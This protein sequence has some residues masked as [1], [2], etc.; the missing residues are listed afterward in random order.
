MRNG[1]DSSKKSGLDPHPAATGLDRRDFLKSSLAVG[2]TALVGAGMAGCAAVA[3][4]EEPTGE[5]EIVTSSTEGLY[6]ELPKD[7]FYVGPNATPVPPLPVPATWDDVADV[8]VVGTGA[9]GCAATLYCATKGQKVITVEKNPMCGGA[10]ATA[11]AF[12]CQGGT[13]AQNAAGLPFDI[14]ALTT[15][16]MGR[17]AYKPGLS[18]RKMTRQMIVKGPEA[19]DWFIDQGG[20]MKLTT[21]ITY[22]ATNEWDGERG[23]NATNYASEKAVE[24]G[25]D[26]RLETECIRLIKEGERVV[27]IKV[28]ELTSGLEY[29]IKGERGVILCAGGFTG[30]FDMLRRWCPSAAQTCKTASTFP[31]DDGLCVRLGQGAGAAM[32]GWDSF[33]AFDGGLDVGDWYH[34]I[35]EG[36]VQ[37]ARQPWLGIDNRG[38]RYPYIAFALEGWGSLFHQAQIFQGLPNSTGYV[39]FDKNWEKNTLLFNEGGC[40]RGE[41]PQVISPHERTAVDP[42]D[43]TQGVRRG[44]ERGHIK[45][46]DNFADI[47]TQLDLDPAI[48]TEAVDKWNKMC[49]EGSDPDLGFDPLWLIPLKDPPFYGMVIGSQLLA[50]QCGLQVNENFEVLDEAGKAIP[51]FYAATMTVGG[52]AGN[53]TNGSLSAPVGTLNL[54]WTTGYVAAQSIL[55][56]L[57]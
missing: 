12:V 48:V 4:A 24:L 14:E 26:I 56:E 46:A 18:Q 38:N 11:T 17:I 44:L 2:A 52:V 22:V 28:K 31:G 53:N 39:F 32:A 43:W 37:V 23:V 55:G 30:N 27:G 13:R 15:K 35:K 34:R 7:G 8:V 42:D 5:P 21:P 49:E 50:T 57:G 54:S 41:T 36:D 6:G 9:G 19:I 51:G 3:H 20:P 10:S 29:C 1:K 25:A 16:Y 45:T 33:L 40:R 47:A